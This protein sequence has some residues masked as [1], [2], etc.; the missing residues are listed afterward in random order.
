MKIQNFGMLIALFILYENIRSFIVKNKPVLGI[1]MGDAA[2][3]G[4]EIIAKIDN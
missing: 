3:V 1:L 2:G 4:P